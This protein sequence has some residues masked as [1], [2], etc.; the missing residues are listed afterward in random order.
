[1][2]SDREMLCVYAVEDLLK[3]DASKITDQGLKEVLNG[4][5]E[6][7]DPVVAIVTLKD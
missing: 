4:I 6:Y 1:M 7:S 5:N 2:I 3:L